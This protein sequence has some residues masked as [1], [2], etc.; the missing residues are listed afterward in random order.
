[1]VFTYSEGVAM[2]S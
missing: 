1:V 2:I